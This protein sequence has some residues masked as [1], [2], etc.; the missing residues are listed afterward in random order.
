MVAIDL[1]S[2]IE[3]AILPLLGATARPIVALVEVTL[4]VVLVVH[5]PPDVVVV[6]V[7]AL[8]HV[9]TEFHPNGPH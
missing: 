9:P 4:V 2:P 7:V 5:P 1:I 8:F 3:N 6:V